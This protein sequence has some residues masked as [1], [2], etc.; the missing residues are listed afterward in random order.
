MSCGWIFSSR[1]LALLVRSMKEHDFWYAACVGRFMLHCGFL[2]PFVF[3]EKR[4]I[5][6][7]WSLWARDIFIILLQDISHVIM[8]IFLKLSFP[9]NL[10]CGRYKWETRAQCDPRPSLNNMS[11]TNMCWNEVSWDQVTCV[12]LALAFMLI[13]FMLAKMHNTNN[14][15]VWKRQGV[16]IVEATRRTSRICSPPPTISSLLSPQFL[17]VR[18]E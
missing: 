15:F 5:K 10:P 9:S 12:A 16:I 11:L 13:A 3:D 7:S 18:R 8:L 1:S 14:G 17:S 2:V 4:E 6:C